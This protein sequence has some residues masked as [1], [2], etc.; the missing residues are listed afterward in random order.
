MS[1]DYAL[2]RLTPKQARFV[3]EYLVEFNGTEAAIRAGYSAKTAYAQASRLLKN[4][5]VA[6]AVVLGKAALAERAKL[7]ADKVI[8]E[9]AKIGFANMADYMK[10]TP[11]GDPYL[12]FAS[13][14]RDQAA[15]LQEVTVD[16]YIEGHGEDAREVKRVRF[17]LGDKRA[18]LTDLGR[19]FGIFNPERVE[20]TGPGGQPIEVQDVRRRNLDLLDAIARRKAGGTVA[21]GT[22][23]GDG[24]PERG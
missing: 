14:T 10:A 17:K 9:L 23:G 12:D 7:S 15:A 22:T 6:E 18:A 21:G 2:V 1:G 3:D 24:Q 11:E 13:L 8:A 20:L 19:H 4:V 5:K 16:R